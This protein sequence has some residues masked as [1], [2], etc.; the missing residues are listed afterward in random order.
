LIQAIAAGYF[1]T[2]PGL[3]VQLVRKHLNKPILTAKG[4]KKQT[5]QGT[6]SA[7]VKI[8]PSVPISP[9]PTISCNAQQ[10]T[11]CTNTSY[12]Y[13]RPIEITGKIYSDQKGRFPLT[14]SRCNKYI[15]IVYSYNSNAILTEPLSSRTENELP[16]AYT[17]I[18]T[19]LTEHGLKP[20]LQRLD[21]EAPGKVKQFMA[22]NGVS[23]QLVP[24]HIHRRNLAERAIG[25][26]KDHFI[27]GLSSLNPQSPM[28]LWCHLIDQAT[29][30]LNLMRPSCI[31]PRLSAEAQLNGAFDYNHTPFAPPGTR[32]LVHEKVGQ[33]RTWDT[34]GIDG[35]YLGRA[36]EHY[37]SYCV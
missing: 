37:C 8:K 25:T 18:H 3:T 1:T 6:R 31:N 28:H 5:R 10:S 9:A 2:W 7:Q 17:V 33:R 35:W 26:W 22:S 16:Q 30:T 29:T 21:N 13:M 23:Y 12:Y 20:T 19:K 15:M 11:N 27:A 32:V 4:H 36:Y 34:K 24:P 14:S